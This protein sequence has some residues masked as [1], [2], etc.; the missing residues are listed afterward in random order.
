MSSGSANAGRSGAGSGPD[1]RVSTLAAQRLVN[2]LVRGLL[3]TP[4]LSR[5]VGRRLV[6]L[7][8]VGRTSGRRYVVPVAYLADGDDLL[9]GTSFA[10][11]RN[12]RA[13]EPITIRLK[14]RRRASDVQVWTAEADVVRAYAHMACTNPTFAAFNGIRLAEDGEPDPHDLHLAWRGGAR[15]IRL[16]PR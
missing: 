2:L 6:V 15:V 12:L 13:G 3:R 11:G 1:S 10:W 7:Y 9:I 5:V 4:G 16:S 8:V 14:G